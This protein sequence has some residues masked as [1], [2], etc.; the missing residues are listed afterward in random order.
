[1]KLRQKMPSLMFEKITLRQIGMVIIFYPTINP[2]ILRALISYEGPTGPSS[3]KLKL[4]STGTGGIEE[5][6]ENLKD[7]IIGFAL[8]RE[9]DKVTFYNRPQNWPY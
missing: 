9:T 6:S 5:L 4:H 7:D 2:N 3:Q 8:L 1:M